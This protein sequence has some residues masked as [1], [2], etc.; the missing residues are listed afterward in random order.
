MIFV[1]IWVVRICCG[2]CIRLCTG[3][4]IG[5]RVGRR[6]C[7]RVC[8]RVGWGV[9]RRVGCCIGRRVGWGAGCC[10]WMSGVRGWHIGRCRGRCGGGSCRVCNGRKVQC[11]SVAY[12]AIG[13]TG[14]IIQSGGRDLDEVGRVVI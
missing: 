6:V 2:R 5:R 9:C 8:R 1:F 3:G 7:R 14:G 10:G 12:P 4:C 13:V 11:R